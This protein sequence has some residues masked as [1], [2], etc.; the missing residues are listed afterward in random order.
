VA[1]TPGVELGWRV[2][3]PSGLNSR[4]PNASSMGVTVF[5]S[6]ESVDSFRFRTNVPGFPRW[7]EESNVMAWL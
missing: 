3:Q 5:P 6:C 2:A 7:A 4:V 1:R